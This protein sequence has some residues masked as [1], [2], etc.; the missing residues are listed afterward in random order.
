MGKLNNKDLIKT[1][2]QVAGRGRPKGTGGNERKDV[3]WGGNKE[4]KPGD[5]GRYL[6]HSL[7]KWDLP[8][9]DMADPKQV[10]ERIV[11]YFKQCIE[12][13]IKPTVSGMCNSLGIDRRTFYQWKTGDYRATTHQDLA[14]KAQSI[15]EEM[16]ETMMVEGKINPIVGIFLGKNHFGYADKQDIVVTPNNPLGENAD[17]EEIQKRYIDSV[18]VDEIYAEDD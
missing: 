15:L 8:V 10:E 11:W 1:G 6:R 17:P 13:D 3:S 14:K 2:K 18:V 4:V 16:W 9:L 12:D 7:A 5:M